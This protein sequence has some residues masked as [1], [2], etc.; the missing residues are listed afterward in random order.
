MATA[1]YEKKRRQPQGQPATEQTAKPEKTAKAA[2]TTTNGEEDFPRGGADALTA[3]ERKQLA[4]AAKAEV[5]AEFAEGKQQ[6]S[7]KPRTGKKVCLVKG[8]NIM[9]YV[10]SRRLG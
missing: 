9:H 7:K 3:L 2:V 6:K 5:E 1:Q 4:E 10:H 8:Q